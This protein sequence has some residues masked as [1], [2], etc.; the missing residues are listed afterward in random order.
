MTPQ[1]RKTAYLRMY[2]SERFLNSVNHVLERDLPLPHEVNP[3]KVC[4][5][6]REEL[7][8]TFDNFP[9]IQFGSQKLNRHTTGFTCLKCCGN[10]ISQGHR[11]RREHDRIADELYQQDAQQGLIGT[12]KPKQ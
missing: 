8:N 1:R 5:K 3:R 9:K 12:L 7:S 10:A 4:G 2:F 11:A 6:C